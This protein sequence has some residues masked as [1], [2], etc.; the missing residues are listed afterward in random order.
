MVFVKPKR[1]NS[2]GI[3]QISTEIIKAG[4]SK[5]CSDIHKLINT[6]WNKEKLPEDWK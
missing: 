2:P 3:D 1:H 4:V 5:M 6:I